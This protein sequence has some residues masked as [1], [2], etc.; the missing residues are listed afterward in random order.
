MDLDQAMR[1]TFAAR[2]YTGDPLPDALL[3]RILDAARF[4]PSGGNR[5]GTRVILI[6]DHHTR[7][8]IARLA[9]PAA[10]RYLAQLEA[11]EAPWNTVVP[12]AVTPEQVAATPVPGWLLA[13]YTEAEVLLVFVVDLHTLAAMDQELDRIGLI[14]G[15]SVYPFV[16]NVLLGA[17]AAGFGGTI[18]TLPA[19]QEPALQ[20]L[21]HIPK[22]HAV[23]AL[24]PLGKPVRQLT[25]LKRLPVERLAMRETFDGPAFTG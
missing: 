11:G 13:P 7:A 3:Y 22:H 4:A 2:Q 20:Q 25:R 8:E 16:W 21:L 1:T 5:Q 19:A 23:C 6:R 9:E 17:R 18:T 24:V 10:R 14:G 15:A 12:S